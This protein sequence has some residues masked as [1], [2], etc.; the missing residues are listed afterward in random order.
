MNR[1]QRDEIHQRV[2][3]GGWRAQAVRPHGSPHQWYSDTYHCVQV[4]QQDRWRYTATTAATAATCAPHKQWTDLLNNDLLDLHDDECM[5]LCF[6]TVIN[7]FSSSIV[8]Q[9]NVDGLDAFSTS[10]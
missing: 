4:V 2:S 7:E 10:T 6:I 9:A 3:G 8:N 5:D 1:W